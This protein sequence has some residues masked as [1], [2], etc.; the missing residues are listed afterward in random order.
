M[1]ET[2]EKVQALITA[3]QLVV[4]SHGDKELAADQISLRDVINGVGQRTISRGSRESAKTY[5]A[6]S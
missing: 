1:S 4:S 2:L 3:G 6:S 5:R